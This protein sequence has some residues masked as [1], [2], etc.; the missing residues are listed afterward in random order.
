M[1][2]LFLEFR[3][4]ALEA[5]DI[6]ALDVNELDGVLINAIHFLDAPDTSCSVPL[7]ALAGEKKLELHDGAHWEMP[8]R[9][10]ANAALAHV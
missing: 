2:A 7:L 3:K 8:T 5:E 9:A 10:E 6:D 4:K 1:F